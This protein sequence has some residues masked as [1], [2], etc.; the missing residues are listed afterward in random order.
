DAI[1]TPAAPGE[2]PRDLSVT[3]KPAFNSLWTLLG[4]PAV[5]LPLLVGQNGLPLGVQLVGRKGEDQRL[6]RTAAWLQRRLDADGQEIEPVAGAE[7][8]GTA[9]SQQEAR[10]G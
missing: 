5:T 10:I 4:L 3:G 6:I 8:Q 2:A 1:V 9:R 7:R